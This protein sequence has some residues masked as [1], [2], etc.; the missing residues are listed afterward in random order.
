MNPFEAMIRQMDE[1]AKEEKRFSHLTRE[2]LIERNMESNRVF[3]KYITFNTLPEGEDRGRDIQ[4][5][6]KDIQAIDMARSLS[7]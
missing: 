5:L 1:K 2:Q 6:L 3:W 4:N 7:D